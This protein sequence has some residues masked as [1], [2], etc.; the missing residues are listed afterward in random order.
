MRDIHNI[1]NTE[2]AMVLCD[3]Q[4]WGPKN[5][6]KTI[7]P[8]YRTNELVFSKKYTLINGNESIQMDLDLVNCDPF[9][10]CLDNPLVPSNISCVVT[11]KGEIIYSGLASDADRYISSSRITTRSIKDY[12]PSNLMTAE[13]TKEITGDAIIVHYGTKYFGHR[14]LYTVGL[15][16]ALEL[17]PESEVPVYLFGEKSNILCPFFSE[18]YSRLGV[19]SDNRLKF[20]DPNFRN[21]FER[22]W[23]PFNPIS[24]GKGTHR[25]SINFFDSFRRRLG[26]NEDLIPRR[27]KRKKIY[28]SRGDAAYRRIINEHEII[29][30]LEKLGFISIEAARYSLMELMEIFGQSEIIISALGSNLVNCVFAPPGIQVG[31]FVPAFYDCDPSNKNA[32][33][34]IVKGCGQEYYRIECDVIKEKEVKY[35]KWNF[36]VPLNNVIKCLETMFDGLGYGS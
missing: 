6:N 11:Q 33:S 9:V 12:F 19:I 21:K 29:S 32:L 8:K 3:L 25:T 27:N 7:F 30:A 4:T 22:L 13:F 34:S 35:S 28:I 17:C 2:N 14:M 5:A 10:V 26:I 18:I 20:I 31:E 24:F 23:I 36:Y 16:N 15:A 1:P